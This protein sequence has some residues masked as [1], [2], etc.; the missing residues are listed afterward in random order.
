MFFFWFSPRIFILEND[1]GSDP[2]KSSESSGFNL[3]QSN[4]PSSHCQRFLSNQSPECTEPRP[5]SSTPSKFQLIGSGETGPEG[6]V[7]SVRVRAWEKFTEKMVGI[8]MA[9]TNFKG[10]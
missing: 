9:T 8:T 3:L 1:G 5:L 10:H 2:I 4:S 6:S 7:W